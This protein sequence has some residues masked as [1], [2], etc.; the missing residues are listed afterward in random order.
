[1]TRII[2]MGPPGSGKGTQASYIA[3]L[4]QVNS[5]STGDLFRS[6]LSGGTELGLIAKGYME[7]GE[8]VPD[9]ITIGMIMNWVMNPQNDS[10]F[11]LDGFPR[12]MRQAEELDSRLGHNKVDMVVF[13]DVAFDLLI[14]RL[15]GRWICQACQRPFHHLYAPPDQEKICNSCGG[16][17]Y[18]REDDKLE[19]V[20]NRLKIYRESTEPVLEYY[21]QTNKLQNLD[22][23]RSIE[24]VRGELASL[25]KEKVS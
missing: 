15:T 14:E 19:V 22:A 8:Y 10:G 13:F 12:T 16:D 17:L 23:S 25:L 9:D 6:N 4:L 3:S 20:E 24:V 21:S 7:S 5:I 18:Q 11:V 2:L 1:M